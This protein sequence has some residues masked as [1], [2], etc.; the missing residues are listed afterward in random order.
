MTLCLVNN[1]SNL[2]ELASSCMV[3]ELSSWPQQLRT[4]I[5]SKT[6]TI[7]YQRDHNT[8]DLNCYQHCCEIPKYRMAISHSVPVC[9][10]ILL[11]KDGSM[12]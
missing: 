11:P 2:L 4:E 12:M 5:F 10:H 6:S 7:S 1:Y 8:E 3:Q 9:P